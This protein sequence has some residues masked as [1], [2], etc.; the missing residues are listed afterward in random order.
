MLIPIVMIVLS[1]TLPHPVN[2]WANIIVGIIFILV[3]ITSLPGSPSH[4][5]LIIA[6]IVFNAMTV[7]YAW[8][9]THPEA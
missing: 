2:R 7:W 6:G 4:K 3:N 9:W 8:N 5:F 1:L